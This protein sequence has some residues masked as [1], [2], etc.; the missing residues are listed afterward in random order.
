MHFANVAA[1]ALM[2]LAGA[3]VISAKAFTHLPNAIRRRNH[4]EDMDRQLD[5]ILRREPQASVPVSQPDPVLNQTIATGC[6][7][8]LNKLSTVDNAAGL[9]A[10]YNI[11]E[12]YPDQGAFQADLRLYQMFPPSG[13]FKGLTPEEMQIGLT[14]PVSTTFQSLTKRKKRD[15]ERRQTKALE[16]QQYSL[17]ATFEKTLDLNKLNDTQIMSLMLPTIKLNAVDAAQSPISANI[18]SEDGA[19]FVVGQFKGEYKTALVSSTVA[20]AAIG[21]AV[22]FVLPGTSLGIFPTGLIITCAWTFLF[23]LAYGFGTFGRIKYRDVYR[24]RKAAQA[25]RTGKRI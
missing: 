6:T 16:I 18:T 9:A 15:L 5:R 11:M 21:A 1:I 13:D 8:V 2:V 25:G 23:F 10:C 24:R 19:W 3:D 20:T 12:Y 14:Y 17:F 4:L 7:D 22:P